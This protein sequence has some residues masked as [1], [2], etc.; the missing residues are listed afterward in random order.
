MPK[1]NAQETKQVVALEVAQVDFERLCKAR[2]IKTVDSD[3][4]EEEQEAFSKLRK[5]ICESI[6]EGRLEIDNDDD[7]VLNPTGAEATVPARI[8]FKKPKGATFLAMD[9]KSTNMAK[10]FAAW[11]DMSGIGAVH[12]SN[13]QAWDVELLAR[14]FV[15]FF[16]SR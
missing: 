14:L 7:P 16:A 6:C 2:R 8:K 9:G 12:F 10:Q 11:A 1:D 15:L 3:W 4:T 13:L 5:H